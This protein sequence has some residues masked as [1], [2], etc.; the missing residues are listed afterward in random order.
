MAVP[1]PPVPAGAEFSYGTPAQLLDASRY[2]FL[3]IGRTYDVAPGDQRF[4]FL[5][6]PGTG[7]EAASSVEVIV[8]WLDEVRARVKD[9]KAR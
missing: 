3:S 1:V 6:R 9:G 5:L 8:H 7:V 4:I 2:Q